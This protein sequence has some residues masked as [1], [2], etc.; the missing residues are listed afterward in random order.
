MHTVFF[1]P[2]LAGGARVIPVWGLWWAMRTPFF[3]TLRG[4]VIRPA[5]QP[6]CYTYFALLPPRDQKNNSPMGD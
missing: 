6:L 2:A 5:L 3:W 1:T 4:R